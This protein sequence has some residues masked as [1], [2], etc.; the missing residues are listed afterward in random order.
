MLGNTS[1]AFDETVENCRYK[2]LFVKK[3][4]GNEVSDS[5]YCNIQHKRILFI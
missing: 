3:H 4:R 5:I 2:E 1:L